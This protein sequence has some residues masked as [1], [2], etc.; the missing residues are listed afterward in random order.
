MLIPNETGHLF[1]EETASGCI[2]A[3]EGLL[4]FVRIYENVPARE[5][6]VVAPI[7]RP[8]GWLVKWAS[9]WELNDVTYRTL[10]KSPFSTE[11]S[12]TGK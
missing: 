8:L 10:P 2:V 1:F 6:G 11:I 9:R 7:D 3:S 4:V 5:R 12:R